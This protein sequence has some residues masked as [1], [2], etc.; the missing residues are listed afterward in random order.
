MFDI[1]IVSLQWVSSSL[2]CYPCV[3]HGSKARRFHFA[4]LS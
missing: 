2:F 4:V 1:N 3:L